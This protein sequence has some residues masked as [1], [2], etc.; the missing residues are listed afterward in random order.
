MKTEST[1]PPQLRP[2]RSESSWAKRSAAESSEGTL[3]LRDTVI[4]ID[5]S[6]IAE[7]MV[8]IRQLVGP[9][10]AVAAVVK[11][12]A[13]GHGALAVAPTLLESGA[14]MLAVATLGEALELRDHFPDCPLLVMG[15]V[16]DAAL[17]LAAARKI[18]LTIDSLHQARLLNEAAKKLGHPALIHI[19]IDT[20]FHRIGFPCNEDGL[21]DINAIK[22]L[23]WLQ[24]EGIFSHLALLDDASN[25]LQYE[26]FCQ[27]VKRL[28]ENGFS[29]RYRHLADS[30]ALVDYPEYRMDMVRAGALIYGL[31]GFH[32]G[33][34][35][36]RQALTF[37]TK[38]CHITSIQKGEG[39][40][41]DY[42][43]KAPYDTKVGTLPFGYAD[44]YPRN[45]RGKGVVSIRGV[46]C[47]L[48]G[49]LCMDQCM[50]DLH[51]VPDAEIGDIAII[52]GDG[53]DAA[54]D[55]Q[56]ISTLAGTNKNEIVAR[57]SA[58]PQR[59]YYKSVI[60]R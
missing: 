12:N 31:R 39:V 55:I 43:W 25:R 52:Y 17:S 44:G 6:A 36:V 37:E 1:A 58:R 56:E 11:A 54:P 5:L 42:T 2:S 50:V 48:V 13:Y 22:D 24:T 29:F 45:L 16:P 49:V 30:I 23:P 57:L 51:D 38:I 8:N 40:S 20:G 59:F 21:R 60:D 33:Y 41:Y 26:K 32:K 7:N 27:I 14:S 9:D 19:K 34:V 46:R 53:S 3:S 35:S 4:K 10:V 28:E 15:L 47:P 18:T